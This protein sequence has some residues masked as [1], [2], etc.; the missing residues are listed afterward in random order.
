MAKEARDFKQTTEYKRECREEAKRRK[1]EKQ[2]SDRRALYQL[3]RD[4]KEAERK[5]FNDARIRSMRQESDTESEDSSSDSESESDTESEDSS[6]N[7]ESIHSK[8][9]ESDIHFKKQESDIEPDDSSSDS[10]STRTRR[11]RASPR[12]SDAESESTWSII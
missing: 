8:K 1:A 12:A 10:Q 6:S 11:S 4:E 5:K 9:E 7:S 2:A 3:I